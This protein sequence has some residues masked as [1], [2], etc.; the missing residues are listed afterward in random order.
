[1]ED[2]RIPKTE[3]GEA[4]LQRDQEHAHR[5]CDIRGVVHHEFVPESQTVNAKIYGNVLR[6][7]KEDI[8]RK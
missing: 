6:C 1:M 5:V 4:E 8:R 2:P 3:E 7:L